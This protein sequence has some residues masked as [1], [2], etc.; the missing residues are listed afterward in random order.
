MTTLVT[1]AGLVV[2]AV[3]AVRST[4]SPCGRSMLSTITPIGERGR[5]NRFAVTAAW[6]VVGGVI[7][8]A[9]LGGLGAGLAVAVGRAAP[10]PATTGAIAAAAMLLAAALD[11][12]L[13]G[14]RLPGHRRQVNERWLDSFRS[15]VYGLGFGWQIGVGLAT[16]ITTAGVYLVVVLGVLSGSPWSALAIGLA[17]GMVRGLAVLAG[18]G[19]RSPSELAAFHRRFD[20]L[21]EPARYAVVAVEASG[22]AL[23]ASV[24]WSPAAIAALLAA[25]VLVVVVTV[26]VSRGAQRRSAGREPSRRVAGVNGGGAQ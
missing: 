12:R 24:L 21:G 14:I 18:R 9:C 3:A 5:G 10:T 20:A 25:G 19:I 8:G 13:G 1:C 26:R 11:A 22:A 23:V 16:Y 15:G 2:A 7:G 6:F 17:F 4:W